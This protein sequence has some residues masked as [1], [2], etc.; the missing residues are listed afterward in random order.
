MSEQPGAAVM[1]V[2]AGPTGLMMA[3]GLALHR[4]PCR[5]IDQAPAPSDKSKALAIHARTLETF[6]SIGI[7]GEA[8]KRGHRLRGM[9]I[10][11]DGHPV[12]NV[13]FE[14]IP[15]RYPF[16][17]TLP[18]SETERLMLERLASF[19][20]QVERQTELTGLRQTDDGVTATLRAPD[21]GE[22]RVVTPYLVGC[23]GAHST[24][25]HVL[26]MPFEGADYEESLP[27]GRYADQLALP[28]GRGAHVPRPGRRRRI[29]SVGWRALPDNRGDAAEHS[30][31]RSRADSRRGPG[32]GRSARAAGDDPERST[33]AGDFSD[34][35]A[36]ESHYRNGRVFVAGDAAHIH[37][38]AGGQ[39]MN[40]GIQ[41][42]HN[43][44]WKLAL[45]TTGA[46]APTLLDSFQAERHAVAQQVLRTS[47]A[48]LRMATIAQSGG[49]RG[50]PLPGSGDRVTGIRAEAVQPHDGGGVGKLP[51]QSDRRRIAPAPARRDAHARA[52]R[53]GVVGVQYRTASWRPRARR[54]AAA[55]RESRNAVV[56]RAARSRPPQSAAFWRYRGRGP[57][58]TPG[59]ARWP[60]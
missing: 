58:T 54:V 36:Q 19:G 44:A 22:E 43:L 47:D 16:V 26:G 40:T 12:I 52:G 10:T 59:C 45:V 4:V 42:A 25:R 57:A 15:S 3:L 27:A 11:V 5:I 38:P 20:I 24:V 29:F 32:V 8:V 23:D 18:Q 37:S 17:L 60:G 41:D 6:E 53:E 31:G 30:A 56:V 1:V 51:A 48:M 33:L 34:P 14:S 49:A 55:G 21:G 9:H 35:S 46:A 7:A 50:P 28:R 39:G 2:G 13:T